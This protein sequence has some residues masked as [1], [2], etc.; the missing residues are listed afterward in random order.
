M[1]SDPIQGPRRAMRHHGSRPNRPV[2]LQMPL[3]PDLSGVAL[4]ERYELHAVIG[5]GTFGRVYRGRDRRLARWVAVKVIKPWWSEDPEWVENFE[6]EA[7]L[8]AS[9]SDPGIVQIFDVGHASEGLYYVAELVDGES[10]ADRLRSGPLAQA[11]AVDVAEQLARALAH[12]HAQRVVHRDVKPA[13]VLIAAD[14]RVKVGDFG[15]ARLAEGSSEGAAGS[16]AGT[17]RYM[18]PEQA[19]G[20]ATSP[21][22]DVY[23]VG[24]VLYEMLAGHPP[25]QGHSMVE[26]AMAHVH[27]PPPPLPSDTPAS[28]VVIVERALAKDPHGRYRDGEAMADALR[29]ARAD[30]ALGETRPVRANGAD[31]RRGADG[32]AAAAR[33]GAAAGAAVAGESDPT[34]VG[35]PMSPRR[36]INP[37]ERRQRIALFALVAVLVAAAV[38]IAVGLATGHVRVPSVRGEHRRDAA[39]TLRRRGLHVGFRNGYSSAAVGTAIAQQPAAGT[40]VSDGATV[41]VVLSAGPPPVTVPS[42]VGS[43]TSTAQATLSQKRLNSGV[44]QIVAPGSSPGTVM[45]QAPPPGARV[46]PGTTV[47][48]SVAEVPS[49]R[50]LT[51]FGGSDQ[52]QSVP[53]R[54]RGR[55]WRVIYSMGYQGTCTLIFVCSGPTATLTDPHTGATLDSFD[56]NEG[57]D[58]RQA[59]KTGPG[60]YQLSVSPGSDTARWQIT[61]Q[62]LY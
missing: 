14:G 53:F 47:E 46:A 45:S 51:S 56:L 54:I 57:S 18:A 34:R 3:A 35:Q 22:T 60:V 4:D 55:R 31:P 32:A 52:D 12:A 42:V 24:I 61:V 38:V 62:D 48:L 43:V 10:L 27:D 5:E 7:Q 37:A 29:R 2:H 36:N 41:S 6:R 9:I 21:S 28:L 20:G 19:S 23:G 40:R 16:V 1:R 59:F 33:A 11:Q 44:R 39:A 8:L 13:N 15:V 26:L 25:F 17:P 30:L 49:W 50:S 58:Q